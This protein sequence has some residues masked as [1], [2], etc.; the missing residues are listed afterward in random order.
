VVTAIESCLLI[1]FAA[2]ALSLRRERPAL[3]WLIPIMIT[4]LFLQAGM[5]AWAV[6]YPQV[7]VVLALHFG[8][9]LAALASASLAA[10]TVREA[11]RGDPP[12]QAAPAWLLRSSWGLLL[13]LYLLVYSGA[14]IRHLGAAEACQSWPGCSGSGWAVALDLAHR[15]GAALAVVGVLGLIWGIS[16]LGRPRPDLISGAWVL[17]AALGGQGVAGA[18]LVRSDFALSGEMLH[19]G[20]TGAVFTAAAWLCLKAYPAKAQLEPE[21]ALTVP[22]FSR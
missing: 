13:Y 15:V 6:K 5:G 10:F 21:P 1:A 14:Y 16:R 12:R 18:Y 11:V 4:T 20:V 3:K 2:L 7:A 19:A 17:L 9:S 8:I 22:V